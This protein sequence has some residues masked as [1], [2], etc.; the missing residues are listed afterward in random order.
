MK[1][2]RKKIRIPYDEVLYFFL[3]LI[4]WIYELNHPAFELTCTCTGKS[5]VIKRDMWGTHLF[6]CRCFMLWI[7]SNNGMLYRKK[8]FNAHCQHSKLKVRGVHA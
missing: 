2:K 7:M 8:D 1:T 6:C 3:S 4:P 5:L